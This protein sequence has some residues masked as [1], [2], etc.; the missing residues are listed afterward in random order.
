MVSTLDSHWRERKP[1]VLSTIQKMLS[2]SQDWTSKVQPG[3]I[4]QWLL[5]FLYTKGYCKMEMGIGSIC[6]TVLM[7][8]L[9]A[10]HHNN[11]EAVPLSG[12]FP[13]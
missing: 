2:I 13:H 1:E 9:E 11:G 7:A 4:S 12:S 3:A 5:V 6:N 10:F 8:A